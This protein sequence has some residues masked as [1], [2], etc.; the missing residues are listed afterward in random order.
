VL[1]YSHSSRC[2]QVSKLLP[3]GGHVFPDGSEEWL[4]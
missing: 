4:A 1:R 2:D 3:Q